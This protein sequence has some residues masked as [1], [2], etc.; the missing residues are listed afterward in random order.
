MRVGLEAA[1]AFALL[2]SGCGLGRSVYS[3]DR[4]EE[5]RAVLVDEHGE[6]VT[7]KAADLPQPPS[8]GDVLVDFQADAKERE[9][10]LYDIRERRSRLLQKSGGGSAAELSLEGP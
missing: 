9:R 1:A 10:L 6:T 5:G 4:V 3:V 8:E 2:A 7:V